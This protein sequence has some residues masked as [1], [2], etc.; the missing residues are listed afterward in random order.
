MQDFQLDNKNDENIY[1]THGDKIN[2]YFIKYVTLINDFLNYAY[3]NLTIE[4]IDVFKTNVHKGIQALTHIFKLILIKTNDINNAIDV[5]QRC[6]SI[7][8]NLLRNL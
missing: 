4:N 1:I 2:K 8:L 3:N 7:T 6:S 5:T